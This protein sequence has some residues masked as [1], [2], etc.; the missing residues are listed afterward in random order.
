MSGALRPFDMTRMPK[1]GS[2]QIHDFVE[3]CELVYH[4]SNLRAPFQGLWTE[5]VLNVRI[6]LDALIDAQEPR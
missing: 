3:A 2:R 1:Y 4:S 5:A 6:A